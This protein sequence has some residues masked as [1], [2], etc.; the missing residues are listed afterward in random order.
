MQLPPAD[1]DGNDMLC[2][3]QQQHLGEAA[4][5]GTNIE[6]YPIQRVDAEDIQ[7]VGQLQSA[8]RDIRM[9]RISLDHGVG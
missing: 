7:S 4:R 1:I 8:A 2:S 9:G 5:G 3:F 6:A